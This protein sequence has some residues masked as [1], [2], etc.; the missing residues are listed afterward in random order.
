[1]TNPFKSFPEWFAARRNQLSQHGLWLEGNEPGRPDPKAFEEARVRVL[2]ARL[3]PYK[4]VL[5]SITHRLLLCAAREVPGVYAD[6]AFFP[7]E[8]DARVMRKENVPFWLATGT[9]K[10][11]S[12]FDVI[13]ISLSVQQEAINLP[14]ALH[15]SG[16]KLGHQDRMADP[17]HP[18]ILMGGHAAGAVPFIHGDAA[19]D[20]PGGLVDAICLGDGVSWFQDFLR[21]LL[22]SKARSTSKQDFLR[23]LAVELPGTYVPAF[24]RHREEVG[25]LAAIEPTEAGLPFPV[26][27]RTDSMDAWLKSYDGAMIPFSDE[28]TEETLPLSAGCAYRCRFCQTGWMRRQLSSSGV[29]PIREAALR[30]KACAV[31]SDLNLLASDACSV[32]AM[33]M[34]SDTLSPLFKHVSV[35]SL[36][37]SSLARKPQL[38]RLVQALSKHEFTFGVEG[39]SERL[40]AYFGKPASV[41]DLAS[42]VQELTGSGLRQIKLFFIATGLE[43]EKDYDELAR[44]LKRIRGIAPGARL[45]A[46]FMPLFN[47]P[48]TPLQF[49]PLRTPSEDQKSALSS[50]VAACGGEF[51]WSASPEEIRLMNRL[52]RAGRE[53]TPALTAASLEEGFRYYGHLELSPARALERILPDESGE[54]NQRHVFP[55]DDLQAGHTKA[56]LWTAYKKGLKELLATLEDEMASGPAR[57][58]SSRPLQHP[59][60]PTLARLGFWGWIP[61]SHAHFPDHVAAR[62]LL[63]RLFSQWTDGVLPYAGNPQILRPPHTSGLVFLSADFRGGTLP[64]SR[65]K[66]IPFSDPDSLHIWNGSLNLPTNESVTWL[67]AIDYPS[68]AAQILISRFKEERIKFQTVRRGEIRWHIIGQAFR[69]RTGIT[70][71]NESKEC[72]TLFCGK[73]PALQEDAVLEHGV[74]KALLA[75]TGTR[76][77]VCKETLYALVQ[78]LAPSPAPA[79]FNC[80]LR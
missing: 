15:Y 50:I 72:A 54:W 44:L 23:A 11:P 80:L 7:P 77:P 26:E 20:S 4:D 67:F 45:I 57:R 78:N 71:L 6:L 31:N 55:W 8:S 1:M 43:E 39:I 49:A 60:T 46:S 76:C 40:R 29:A 32:P 30:L 61:E 36:S 66:A 22:E 58:A 18:W 14:S 19:A 42:M 10:G 75:Q 28:E 37:I 51:R 9:K 2:I 53:A 35:K 73:A 12:D 79:C 27:A 16:L 5:P 70:T 47:A 13:A 25:K 48:F 64:P 56:S 65:E 52:C 38:L 17:L 62:S 24:Y 69:G 41:P 21:R 74:I 59:A 63:Q 33:D 3:S 68:A 34:V